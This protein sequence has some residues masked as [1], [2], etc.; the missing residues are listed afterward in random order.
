MLPEQYLPDCS[1]DTASRKLVW[2]NVWDSNSS[3]YLIASWY[4]NFLYVSKLLPHNVR[5]DK[6]TGTGVLVTCDIDTDK[7]AWYT[8][9]YGEPSTPNKGGILETKDFE[10]LIQGI[11]C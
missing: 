9:I 3:H 7:E 6:R 2:I 8:V 1:L 10:K 11:L 4:F 5:L